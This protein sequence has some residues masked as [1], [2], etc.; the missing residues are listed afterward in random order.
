VGCRATEVPGAPSFPYVGS[1][2]CMIFIALFVAHLP[3][4]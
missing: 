4:L 1:I 2:D 3:L